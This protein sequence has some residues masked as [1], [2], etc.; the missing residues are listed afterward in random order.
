[1]KNAEKAYFE[2]LEC[3]VPKSCLKNTTNNISGHNLKSVK[4]SHLQDALQSN[5]AKQ[6]SISKQ[7]QFNSQ[8]DAKDLTKLNLPTANGMKQVHQVL[9]CESEYYA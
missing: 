3:A 2:H 8:T 7:Q 4:T 1:M 9:L 5:V 6:S